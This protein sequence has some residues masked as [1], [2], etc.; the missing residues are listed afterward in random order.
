MGLTQVSFCSRYRAEVELLALHLYSIQSEERKS[1]LFL[2]VQKYQQPGLKPGKDS[3]L[4]WAIKSRLAGVE[5][6]TISAP[7]V[8]LEESS[9]HELEVRRVKPS[10]KYFTAQIQRA[11]SVMPVMKSWGPK[12]IMLMLCH[13]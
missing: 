3:S 6:V 10:D 13:L 4:Q 5:A 12:L 2:I 1:H 8:I 9:V 11:C 7:S